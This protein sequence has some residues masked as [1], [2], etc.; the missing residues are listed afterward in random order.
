[1]NPRLCCMAALAALTLSACAA[2]SSRLPSVEMRFLESPEKGVLRERL[3]EEFVLNTALIGDATLRYLR[4]SEL[5]KAAESGTG[6]GDPQ[7]LM[8]AARTLAPGEGVVL[9]GTVRSEAAGGGSAKLAV[10]SLA[11]A[12]GKTDLDRPGDLRGCKGYVL[13]V[14]R[15]WPAEV[16]A[17]QDVTVSL[18]PEGGTAKGRIRARSEPGAFEAW[19]EGEFSAS[20]VELAGSG[21]QASGAGR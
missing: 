18:I 21:A 14:T 16:Y 4:P 9:L 20:V 17:L 13:R 19:L 8:R 15:A 7:K 6:Q 1:M 11:L 3:Q 2:R 10:Y 12:C 5:L